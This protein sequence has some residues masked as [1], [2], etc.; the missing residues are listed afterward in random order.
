[1][2]TAAEHDRAV[3]DVVGQFTQLDP[4]MPIRLAKPTSNLFRARTSLA[5]PGLDVGRLDEVVDVDSHCRTA[6]VQGMATYERVV[7][8]TL[9]HGLMPL[10]VPQ[11]K[12]IT[13]GG[14]VTGLGI[15]STVVPQRPAARVGPRA[16]HPHRHR[17]GG[18]RPAG[19]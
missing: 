10:V 9:A 4:S 3:Q 13:L 16:G 8:A 5:S 15:E 14:A 2:R 11:L 7:D 18:H 19:R 6:R 17:A 12:T 1:M